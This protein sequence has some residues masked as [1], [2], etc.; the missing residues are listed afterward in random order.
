MKED[1]VL[2]QSKNKEASVLDQK[3]TETK[4]AEPAPAPAPAAAPAAPAAPKEKS[5]KTNVGLIVG[6]II[7]MLAVIAAA[8]VLVIVIINKNN[9]NGGGDGNNTGN[10]SQGGNGGTG[11]NGGNGGNGGDSSSLNVTYNGKEI[12]VA[13]SYG[14]TIKNA[15]NAGFK[16]YSYNESYS[17]EYITSSNIDDYLKKS[18]KY[19]DA[20]YVEGS[21]SYSLMNISGT[22]ISYSNYNNLTIGDLVT[23]SF[24]ANG[25]DNS[26]SIRGN[27]YTAGKTTASDIQNILSNCQ[28]DDDEE[29]LDCKDDYVNYTFALKTGSKTVRSIRFEFPIERKY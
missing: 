20:V 3:P 25:D 26:M 6:F 22:P 11:G 4:T 27:T 23:S 19:S 8:I 10:T 16:I 29:Y 15:L 14:E 18:T 24:Y 1:S 13:S 28:F 7:T 17:K 12:K 21:D 5:G 2:N 9:S